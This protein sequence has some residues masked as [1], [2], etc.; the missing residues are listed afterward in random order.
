M[1]DQSRQVIDEGAWLGVMGTVDVREDAGIVVCRWGEN[2]AGLCKGDVL[3]EK[4]TTEGK[5]K[6]VGVTG[7]FGDTEKH[8]IVHAER[9]GDASTQVITT[10]LPVGPIITRLHGWNGVTCIHG[11]TSCGYLVLG[12]GTG[13]APDNDRLIL[14][15]HT[16][17]PLTLPKQIPGIWAHATT[18]RIAS[19][20]ASHGGALL[21]VVSTTPISC[22]LSV[23]SFEPTATYQLERNVTIDTL[24]EVTLPV[25]S[26][27]GDVFVWGAAG[28]PYLVAVSPEHH[29]ILLITF[30]GAL[31]HFPAA[32]GL[33][34]R[35]ACICNNYLVAITETDLVVFAS[36]TALLCKQA[37][38][39]PGFSV[40]TV[41]GRVVL[42]M[43]T[44][45]RKLRISPTPS[46]PLAAQ[47]VSILISVL[48]DTKQVSALMH[49]T[50]AQNDEWGALCGILLQTKS[51]LRP[52][53]ALERLRR[54]R[55]AVPDLAPTLGV[56][57][58]A[59][60][61]PPQTAL[62]DASH[63]RAAICALHLMHEAMRI[64]TVW[65][66]FLSDL[67]VLIFTLV[68]Q[69]G[70]KL[71]AE[72]YTSLYPNLHLTHD[73]PPPYPPLR[74]DPAA[75]AMLQQSFKHASWFIEVAAPPDIF[76]YIHAAVSFKVSPSRAFPFIS[77]GRPASSTTASIRAL[78][79]LVDL[80]YSRDGKRYFE[81]GPDLTGS[82]HENAVTGVLKLVVD[83]NE[84]MERV[85]ASLSLGPSFLLHQSVSACRVAPPSDWDAK[86]LS[87]IG[88]Q[89]AAKLTKCNTHINTTLYPFSDYEDQKPSPPKLPQAEASS[90]TDNTL[91]VDVGN[92]P[93]SIGHRLLWSKDARLAVAQ[94]LLC[95]AVPIIL[96][97]SGEDMTD[98]AVQ[99]QQLAAM[100]NR[101]LALPCGRG[102]LTLSTMVNLSGSTLPVPPLVLCGRRAKDQAYT[103]LDLTAYAA[104][105][106][107]WPEFLNGCSA[108]LRLQ[109]MAQLGTNRVYIRDWI[110]SA[111]SPNAAPT[112]GTAG[113]VL[114]LGLL[115]HLEYLTGSEVYSL[116]FPRHEATTVALLLG[117]SACYRGT[118]EK[119]VSGMVSLHLAPI[120]P[121]YTE[122]DVAPGMQAAALIGIGL[123]YQGT[124]HRLMVD[125]LL[126]ELSRPPSDEHSCNLHSYALCTGF[127]LGLLCLG[128]GGEA[129]HL[130]DLRLMDRLLALLTCTKW[131]F[132]DPQSNTLWSPPVVP[133]EDGP[134]AGIP[135]SMHRV[136]NRN[137][138]CSKVMVGPLIDTNVTAPAAAAAL[139][140]MFMKSRNEVVHSALMLPT[141]AS[142]LQGVS[143]DAALV[144]VVSAALVKWDEIEA[145]REWAESL[146]PRILH[147]ALENNCDMM[148]KPGARQHL[149]L[150]HANV[151]AGCMFV[152]GLKYAGSE[153]HETRDL[154]LDQ[155]AHLMAYRLGRDGHCR[156]FLDDAG[157]KK[158]VEPCINACALAAS[159]VMA[160]TGCAMVFKVL[161]QLQKRKDALYGSHMAVS[162][163]IGLLFLGAG[164]R[165]LS[166][167]PQAV[168]ALFVS[169]YPRFPT[170]ATD[171]AYHPQFLRP[172]Y[173][174]AT[175]PRI[176]DT[177]DVDTG[178]SC[179]VPV[180]INGTIRETSPCVLP[181]GE[182]VTVE[183]QSDEYFDI[184][185]S[186]GGEEQKK[187]LEAGVI[188]VKKRPSARNDGIYE[189]GHGEGPLE[190]TG[191]AGGDPDQA[192]HAVAG[193]VQAA[194]QGSL[195]DLWDAKLSLAAEADNPQLLSGIFSSFLES[196]MD[197]ATAPHLG[198]AADSLVKGQKPSLEQMTSAIW[199]NVPS[200]HHLLAKI[201]KTRSS[202]A[203]AFPLTS[204]AAV[205]AIASTAV[206]N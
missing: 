57:T 5:I 123:L 197:Q 3:M 21:F 161:R 65:R 41:N 2:C 191:V 163:A 106:T 36:P 51:V 192:Q 193:A 129:T 55:K 9:E 73:L 1:A 176:L 34:F 178:E 87:V 90:I 27:G 10:Y 30:A 198:P 181:R 118:G 75:L 124:C 29:S 107:L 42:R 88:R 126:G 96:T 108:A 17:H 131:E 204:P 12:K 117:L 25:D 16:M 186:K 39:S 59:T 58:T 134:G 38:P 37:L 61:I 7:L 48:S 22:V 8:L 111:V 40:M 46:H 24:H 68:E 72:H 189:K 45:T 23:V 114:G 44:E 15:A 31:Q 69:Q 66:P 140:L 147:K 128:K 164:H 105:T 52:T 151:M 199:H 142:L 141:T 86:L 62:L 92:G 43:Q 53:S 133:S 97:G 78:C 13:P 152:L 113:V 76:T 20:E 184:H 79:H 116:M 149:L 67:A 103:S 139:G 146:A 154:I 89:D 188:W 205:T 63:T 183:V 47:A 35:D 83:G 6:E 173:A 171:N 200:S 159:C 81:E 148:F 85:I 135:L 4:V 33:P 49:D 180:V 64:T 18:V 82:P 177:K 138:N 194:A 60:L 185:V 132:L 122:Q 166:S 144:R 130:A 168:A 104:E 71:W 150:L 203:A 160:G 155:L 162:M 112:A 167:S 182:S 56:N 206:K 187:A 70:W 93:P 28:G 165:T 120:T 190:C 94:S 101:V 137:Q 110:A 50:M 77:L 11:L 100:A 121:H 54:A 136:N 32:A 14:L 172:L 170:V 174:L 98:P 153:C 84:E 91:G 195:H 115:G 169:L 202:L 156:I 143:P 175:M 179:P 157:N 26:C 158:I 127:A 109:S 74:D 125:M 102:M 99:Q 95:S 19:T 196:K 80:R 119:R 145:T 201:D